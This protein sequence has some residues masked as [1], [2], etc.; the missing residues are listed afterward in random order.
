MRVRA[1]GLV[2]AL[3]LQRNS[4]PLPEDATGKVQVAFW[5]ETTRE[6]EECR[7]AGRTSEITSCLEVY[8][9]TVTEV[10]VRTTGR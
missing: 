6:L 9:L 7:G 10:S 5:V 4:T 8:A 3:R 1:R 2:R